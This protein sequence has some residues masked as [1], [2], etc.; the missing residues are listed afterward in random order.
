VDQLRKQYTQEETELIDNFVEARMNFNSKPENFA[1][2]SELQGKDLFGIA[3][4]VRSFLLPLFYLS[5]SL[6]IS[7]LKSL[8]NY[9]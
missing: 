3:E 9:Y 7:Y 1:L 8:L 4:H 5:P 6:S 2:T